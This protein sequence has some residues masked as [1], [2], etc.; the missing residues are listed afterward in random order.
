MKKLLLILI[1]LFVSFE[2]KSETYNCGFNCYG[3][4]N[5]ICISS[6]TRTDNGF[7]DDFEKQYSVKETKEYLN[8]VHSFNELNQGTKEVESVIFTIILN[9][10]SGEFTKSTTQLGKVGSRNGNCEVKKDEWKTR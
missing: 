2:V 10:Y 1:C 9:K 7:V 4:P 3:N 6:Y 5:K 8:L